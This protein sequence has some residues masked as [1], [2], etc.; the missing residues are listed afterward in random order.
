MQDA[1]WAENT[2]E[3]LRRLDGFITQF[4]PQKGILPSDTK[5]SPFEVVTGNTGR[6]IYQAV[7]KC[8]HQEV[9]F[10]VD[11]MEMDGMGKDQ[12]VETI[13]NRM[14]MVANVLVA[15][16][17]EPTSIPQPEETTPEPV[18]PEPTLGAGD[19][20]DLCGKPRDKRR[21][22]GLCRQCAHGKVAV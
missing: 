22:D 3:R 19:A 1:K 2:A 7:V 15:M 20:C 14:R 12:I 5:I 17:V 8:E 13:R 4:Q 9:P 6:I 11:P 21:A 18:Q 10:S 16:G